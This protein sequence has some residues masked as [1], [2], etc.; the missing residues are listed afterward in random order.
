MKSIFIIPIILVLLLKTST[1]QFKIPQVI[2]DA[3]N[4]VKPGNPSPAEIG[5]A[6]KEA[7]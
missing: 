5:S 7:L 2:K 6:I 3:A 4:L 1:A